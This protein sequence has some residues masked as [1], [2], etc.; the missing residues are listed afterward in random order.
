MLR[1]LVYKLGKKFD[2]CEFEKNHPQMVF[3]NALCCL[4]VSTGLLLSFNEAPG[5]CLVFVLPRHFIWY[6]QY[7][8]HTPILLFYNLIAA[9]VTVTTTLRDAIDNAQDLDVIISLL[10][11]C[12]YILLTNLLLYHLQF[13]LIHRKSFDNST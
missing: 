13:L 4:V 3:T 9:N 6:V 11:T 10:L 7:I 1:E 12:S 2:P 5:H 8:S